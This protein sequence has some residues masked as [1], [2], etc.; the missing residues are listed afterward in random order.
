MEGKKIPSSSFGIHSLFGIRF[1]AYSIAAKQVT[2]F[3][4]VLTDSQSAAAQIDRVIQNCV[5]WVSGIVFEI[6]FFFILVHRQD[7]HTCPCLPIWPIQKSRRLLCEFPSNLT[8]HRTILKWKALYWTRFSIK[9]T[10][11]LEM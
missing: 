6:I 7:L 11:R 8:F 4:A 1:D 5:T 10:K 9:S 2:A 3:Q